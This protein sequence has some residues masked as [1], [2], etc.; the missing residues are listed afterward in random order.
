MT[1][2][3]Q[4]NIKVSIITVCFNSA[5]TISETI[6]SVLSQ[7]YDYIEYIIIDGCSTDGTT[8]IIKNFIK[9]NRCKLIKYLSE[10][11]L[12]IYDAMNKGLNLA[13]G[14]IVAFLN[15]DDFYSNS[16]SVSQITAAMIS[17]KT[18]CAFADVIYVDKN[19]TDK[20][21]RHYDSSKFKP[22]M[23]R[24]GFMPAHPTFFAK[25]TLYEL[26][27]NFNTKYLIAADFELLIR[28]LYTAKAKYIYLPSVLIK[29]RSGGVSTKGIS[30]NI[31]IIYENVA[32]CKANNIYTNACMLL[33]KIPFK[34]IE[35][36]RGRLLNHKIK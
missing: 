20:I 18:D 19:N 25:K 23:F 2:K 1:I 10:P 27:G 5:S 8:E 33:L 17:S 16:N 26:V 15:S 4:G 22:S 32:A 13:T 7:D 21:L 36:M 34:L 29:M 6:T 11:D 12:G 3:P 30:S 35:L 9:K 31:R 28:M 24:W 14:D